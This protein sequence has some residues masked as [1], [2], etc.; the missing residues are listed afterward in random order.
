MVAWDECTGAAVD[1]LADQPESADTVAEAAMATCT[2][3]KYKYMRAAGITYPDAVEEATKPQLL[4]RVMATRAARAKLRQ[5]S[6]GIRSAIDYHRAWLGAPPLPPS[7]ESFGGAEQLPP[8]ADHRVSIFDKAD[9]LQEQ[10]DR[11]R[12]DQQMLDWALE[13]A[14]Q[15]PP[16]AYYREPIPDEAERLQQQY[17]HD[18]RIRADQELL[19]WALE[20]LEWAIAAAPRPAG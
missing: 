8:P 2:A 12:A 20:P 4:A 13:S 18:N 15:P 14:R 3:E 19:D 6:P 9:R 10:Y 17:Y 11:G 16:P 7:T 1:K 5:Q